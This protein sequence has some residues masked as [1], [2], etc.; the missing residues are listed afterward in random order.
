MPTIGVP[1]LISL[2]LRTRKTTGLPA[3]SD[4]KISL[5]MPASP[6]IVWFRDSLRLADHPALAAAASSGAPVICLYVFDEES[7]GVRPLGGATRWWLAQSLRS[8]KAGLQAIGSDLVLRRGAAAGVIGALARETNAGRVVWNDIA[9][10]PHRAV[11]E[12]VAAELAASGVES[13]CFPGD[14][15]ADPAALRGKDGRGPRVFTPF[16]K[17]VLALGDPPRPL[18][19]PTSLPRMLAS[20]ALRSTSS[21]SNRPARTGLAACARPGSRASARRASGS[22]RSSKAGCRAMPAT[23]TAPIVTA[24]HGCRRICASARSARGRCGMPRASQRRHGLRD[25]LISTSS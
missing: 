21:A 19:A 18:P 6:I 11:A 23:A 5:G 25:R 3:L 10:A 4:R 14:L 17:R 24:P 12:A 1:L 7:R 22:R 2:N 8:L 20:P 15:L 16:W 9:Q 13:K